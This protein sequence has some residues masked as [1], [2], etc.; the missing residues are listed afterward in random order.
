MDSESIEWVCYNK[1]ATDS[2]A[3]FYSQSLEPLIQFKTGV[4]VSAQDIENEK[5]TAGSSIDPD[6]Y[7]LPDIKPIVKPERLSRINLF[8][9]AATNKIRLTEYEKQSPEYV[10]PKIDKNSQEETEQS[11]DFDIHTS[12]DRKSTRLNSSHVSE[13]RMPSS[14]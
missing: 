5:Y 2:D 14:A 4:P 8:Y 3:F 6:D 10:Y 11:F 7:S 9:F 1:L 12:P 13:S